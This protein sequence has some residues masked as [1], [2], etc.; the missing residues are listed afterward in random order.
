[1]IDN[2][3]VAGSSTPISRTDED[4]NTYQMRKLSDG[5]MHEVLKNFPSENDF[6]D[7][8]RPFTDNVK[9][10]ELDYF[11]IAEYTTK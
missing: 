6:I 1:M 7:Q 3:F 9:F 5:S 2:N 4:G 8:I 11:W 10:T